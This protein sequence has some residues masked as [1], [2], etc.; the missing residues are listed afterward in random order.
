VGATLFTILVK[1]AGLYAPDWNRLAGT[2]ELMI[3]KPAHLKPTRVR[4]QNFET[5]SGLNHPVNH[6]ENLNDHNLT[7]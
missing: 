7:H 4:R 5:L 1:G 2:I 3:K 6:Q